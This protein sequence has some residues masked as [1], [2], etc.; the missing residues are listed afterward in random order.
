MVYI[1]LKKKY[2]YIYICPNYSLKRSKNNNQPISKW[3]SLVARLRSLNTIS[4][5]GKQLLRE[6]ADSRSRAE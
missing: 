6:M 5:K 1:L 4:I 3:V 2:I